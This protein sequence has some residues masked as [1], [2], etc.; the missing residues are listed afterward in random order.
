MLHTQKLW[1]IHHFNCERLQSYT[2]AKSKPALPSRWLVGQFPSDRT[3][4]KYLSLDLTPERLFLN[5][6]KKK[7]KNLW[8]VFAP[9]NEGG[10]TFLPLSQ[11]DI[12]NRSL[13]FFNRTCSAEQWK[14]YT[15]ECYPEKWYKVGLCFTVWWHL[16]A[17]CWTISVILMF[18]CWIYDTG[19][20]S[21]SS[22]WPRHVQTNR[23]SLFLMEYNIWKVWF[24]SEKLWRVWIAV[25][26]SLV[27]YYCLQYKSH[28]GVRWEQWQG[29]DFCGEAPDFDRE[30]S[31]FFS[32]PNVDL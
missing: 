32:P 30:L 9:A 20:W 13:G 24:Q 10:N 18:R 3:W 6:S 19:D 25:T 29:F 16:R 2:S 5:N 7:K 27:K 31:L 17:D 1:P 15:L 28:N 23:F 8:N 12:R 14:H 11:G 22:L 26:S 21:S 4:Q